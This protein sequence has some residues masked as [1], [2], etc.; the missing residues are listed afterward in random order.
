MLPERCHELLTAYV[1]GELT[2]RQRRAVGKLLHRS[3]EARDLLRRLQD[4]AGKL[5][6]LPSPPLEGDLAAEVVETIRA[7][8]LRPRRTPRPVPGFPVWTVVVVTIAV[9]L[10]L[11]VATYLYFAAAFGPANPPAAP[12]TPAGANPYN[13]LP[14]PAPAPEP[15][16]VPDGRP[17]PPHEPPPRPATD[18]G[19]N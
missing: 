14:G 10:V 1:D 2:N 18:A 19:A 3:P 6:A 17:V 16:R 9:L 11:G 8:H 13:G 5:R 15:A 12:Q 4:D 7:R